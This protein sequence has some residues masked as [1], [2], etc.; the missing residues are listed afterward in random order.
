MVAGKKP[1]YWWHLGWDGSHGVGR[2]R[3]FGWS[4][5]LSEINLPR[6]SWERGP[7][8]FVVLSW[9][10]GNSDPVWSLCWSWGHDQ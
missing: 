5:N 4:L 8:G 2:H 7:Y 9:G 3:R 10:N 1:R 6:I